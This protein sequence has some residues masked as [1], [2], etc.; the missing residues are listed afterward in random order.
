MLLSGHF[1]GV[2]TCIDGLAGALSRSGRHEY[3]LH[4]PAGY[5][6]GAAASPRFALRPHGIA[7][8]FRLLRIAWQ[9]T[10]FARAAEAEGAGLIHSPG[11]VAPLNARL[12]V[13]L[14]VYDA[15][16]L[17]HPEWCGAANRLHYRWAL[18]RSLRK[19]ARIIVPSEAT[20]REVMAC[21]PVDP[22]RICVV[23]PGLRAGLAPIKD[24]VRREE[25]RTRLGLPPRY[26]LFVGNL[27][28]KK[29]LS[30]L[31]SSFAVL[32]AGAGR[33]CKLI[34]VGKPGWGYQSLFRDIDRL[35][36]RGEVR[37]AGYVAPEWMAALYSGADLFA[38]PSL[39]EGFG[40]P[41]LEA[42]ACGTPAVVSDAG[43]L[44]EVV[45]DAAVVVRNPDPESFAAAMGQVI[46]DAALRARC[47]ERGLLRAT[48]FS[49]E[50]A[51]EATDNVYDEA[52]SSCEGTAR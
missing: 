34:I 20:R 25:A 52:V 44:P 26:I 22:R 10:Q 35:G 17:S 11:Y 8:R 16:A 9:Q 39:Y 21:V 45:G 5:P 24:P 23:P 18:P 15:L 19:A 2:E 29:N 31:L 36:L 33:Q 48:R 51:R 43:A 46:T 41:P 4:V 12:P 40:L 32:K 27:E 3:V 6:G 28:P 1:S 42:M 47:V 30:F 49:W 37:V 50:G 7:A 38:F 14:T 13:V